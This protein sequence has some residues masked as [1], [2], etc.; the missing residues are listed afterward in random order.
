MNDE[1]IRNLF[2]HLIGMS[3]E[4]ARRRQ[5]ADYYM[6]QETGS[7]L[8]DLVGTDIFV[9]FGPGYI[10]LRPRDHVWSIKIHK[11]RFEHKFSGN[12][13]V[14]EDLMV[15]ARLKGLLGS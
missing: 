14:F 9:I 1:L 11:V 5:G 4:D 10:R 3:Q 13:E 15:R 7:L 2:L 12:Q 6:R 8:G